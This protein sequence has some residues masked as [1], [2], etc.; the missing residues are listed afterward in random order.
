MTSILET[1]SAVEMVQ[2][3]KNGSLNPLQVLEFCIKNS[4]QQQELV[5]WREFAPALARNTMRHLAEAP[6]ESLMHGIPVG[7]KDIMLTHDLPTRYG[8]PLY[9]SGI[10]DRDAYCVK[11]LR[12][13]G[14]VVLGKTITTEFAYFSP[15]PTRN[16]H[17]TGHTPGGSSSG[18]AVAVA[19]GMVPVAMGTQTAGSL[20][21]PASYCGVF[22]LKP[23]FGVV[24][25]QGVKEMAPSLDT[26]GW[27]SRH[28]EDLELVRCALTDTSYQKLSSVSNPRIGICRTHEWSYL[29]RG[30]RAAFNHAVAKLRAA[31][32]ECVDWVMPS[33]FAGLLAAQ[34][35]IQ[36]FEASRSYAAEWLMDHQLISVQFLELIKMGMAISSDEYY[37]AQ[38][39]ASEARA[40]VDDCLST[41][42]A[43]LTPSATGE[44]PAGLG[45]TG[46]PVC[47]RV[48]TMLGHPSVNVPGLTGP[49]RLPIGIQLIG[50]FGS[51]RQLVA[52][53]DNIHPLLYAG[54]RHA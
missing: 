23:G 20:I 44:A 34:Q 26:L 31:D 30:G 39:L 48:W 33:R 13:A 7:I 47:S 24:D 2:A 53:A 19:A 9:T 16:P 27:F 15:G 40:V 5:A 3:M 4:E 32:I 11:K 54:Q 37:A 45:A 18:S 1:A 6:V 35:T 22:A 46:D 42:T 41:L 52:L 10:Y 17:H 38:H 51:E 43:L 36:A 50:A 29:D 14:A 49:N 28:A 8:S 21:R 25:T 12:S